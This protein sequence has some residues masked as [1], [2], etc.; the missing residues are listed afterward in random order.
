MSKTFPIGLVV[1]DESSVRD[2]VSEWLGKLGYVPTQAATG[3]EAVEHLGRRSFDVVVLDLH[4]PDLNGL[5]VLNAVRDTHEDACIVVL[6]GLGQRQVFDQAKT[7]G[8]DV[9]LAKPCTLDDLATAIRTTQFQRAR[10]QR[11]AARG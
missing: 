9:V 11:F 7:L 8:A 10:E 4:M 3:R 6:S 2:L 5:Q 1:D